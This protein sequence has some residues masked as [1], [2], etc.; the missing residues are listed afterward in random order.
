[1]KS[2]MSFLRRAVVTAALASAIGFV[3][4]EQQSGRAFGQVGGQSG[5]G[6]RNNPDRSDRSMRETNR[7]RND[8]REREFALRMMEREAGRPPERRE[9]RLAVT[10]IKNDFVRLQVVNNGLAEAASANALSLKLIAKS[11][12]EIK[13]HADRLRYNLMLPEMEKG[14]QKPKVEPPGEHQQLMSTLLAL[15]QRIVGFVNNPLFKQADVL[16]AQAS[17]DAR[18]DLDLIIE[19]SGSIKK[20]SEKLGK[21]AQ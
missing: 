7:S 16:D 21:A 18:R 10:E 13:K 3:A 1:M 19:L 9:M 6:S 20:S 5:G 15:N 14:Y 12:A 11:A 4:P 2:G 8:L 17:R